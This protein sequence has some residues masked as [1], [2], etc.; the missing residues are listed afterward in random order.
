[1]AKQKS[2]QK[3]PS[4]VKKQAK[5]PPAASRRQGASAASGAKRSESKPR[6]ERELEVLR[7]RNQMTAVVIFAV[8]VLMAFLVLVKGDHVWNWAHNVLLGLFGNCAILWPILLL[9]IAII[10][11]VERVSDNMRLKVWMISGI[12]IMVCATVYIFGPETAVIQKETYFTHLKELYVQGVGQ[13]GAGLISGLIGVLFVSV[14][15]S[16]GSKIVIILLLFVMIMLLTG[17]SLIQLFKTVTKPVDMV[18]ENIDAVRERH[19]L[20]KGRSRDPNIDIALD[21][22]ELPAHPVKSDRT[23]ADP[24][25]KS[26]KLE[27]LEKIFNFTGGASQEKEEEKPQVPQP[28]VPASAPVASTIPVPAPTASVAPVPSASQDAFGSAAAAAA[29]LQKAA[30]LQTAARETAV[31]AAEPAPQPE[32]YHFPPLSML[33]YSAG[34][35]QED[36]TAELQSNG[37]M[38]VGTLKS[39][40]V[41]TKIVDISR[42]P[43]VT[44][45]ELQPAPGVKISKITNLSD[46][47]AMNLAAAGVRIEAPI[48]GKAAV[49]I[50]VPNKNVNVVR[51]RDLVESNAFVSAKSKL[52]VALGRDI[53]GAVAVTD[54]SKMPHLLIA[55]STGSGKSVCINSLIV[56]LLYKSTPDEVRFLMVDPKVVELGIYNGI[57]HLLVPVVTDPRKAAGALGWAVTEMLKRY[58]IFAENNVRD[59]ASYNKL[60]KSKNNQDEEGNPM[61][62]L[63]Q[64]VII[65]DELADL[66]MA[67]PNEVEDSI[68]RLAQMARAAGMHLVIATQRPSVDVI[69]GIIKANI[70]SR[71]AFAVSSQIDS[72]TILDM[73]G[74]E[75]LLGRGDMLFSPVGSQKPIRIQGCFVSDSEIESVVTYVKKVQDSGYDQ[76]V[77]EE[78]ERN[79]VAEKDVSGGNGSDAETT[80]PMMNEAIKCV[81]E[82]GQA[83]TSL[84]QRRLRLGYARAGRLIDEMEQLGVVGPHE[85]S[86]PRQVLLTR[87]QYLEM[88]MQQADCNN[89]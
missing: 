18:A 80:D 67:A 69:T 13:R 79:A 64:I 38:L 3:E 10:T 11:A 32:G 82:A 5:R 73:G 60:A 26:E 83:S 46:D 33:E 15:G 61:P 49:G 59:L 23:P 9:Y 29:L 89:E 31:R 1:M 76:S 74:A 72:R 78:I 53:A 16:V 40:G 2:I 47:I 75:K 12:I 39:F 30:M 86:K 41:Q 70:P 34:A 14:L 54:L 44:R 24:P 4:Q 43:A 87:Q 6:T 65:I 52:T 45:Y 88:T 51:M 57:P 17:T 68:C 21:A 85:G 20:E 27:H 35:N 55:G 58:K 42:G 37:N 50:E 25:E 8:A 77:I 36:I 63:P 48:P 84:L 19:A 56:S 62:H 71:I 66:M 22:D 7:H 81:V 28:S